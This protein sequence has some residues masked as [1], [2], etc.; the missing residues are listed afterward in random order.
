MIQQTKRVRIAIHKSLERTSRYC[1]KLKKKSIMSTKVFYLCKL[2]SVIYT[3]LVGISKRVPCPLL[4]YE[5]LR[6]QLC[7]SCLWSC[8]KFLS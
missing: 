3:Y 2:K 6:D 7:I 8:L 5:D 1:T 4:P